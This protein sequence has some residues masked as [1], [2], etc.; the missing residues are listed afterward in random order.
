MKLEHNNSENSAHLPPVGRGA[1]E[2]GPSILDF[3]FFP[4]GY[5][6]LSLTE[7]ELKLWDL[8]KVEF[9]KFLHSFGV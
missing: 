6:F 4:N 7:T 3:V 9:Q 1:R 2:G 5:Y 8:R